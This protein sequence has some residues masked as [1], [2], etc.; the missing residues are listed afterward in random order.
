MRTVS[1][2]TRPL[3]TSRRPRGPVRFRSRDGWL[4]LGAADATSASLLTHRRGRRWSLPSIGLAMLTRMSRIAAVG[5][6]RESPVMRV[7]VSDDRRTE[8]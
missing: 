3:I 6:R 1:R 8:R 2:N 5:R 4:S 7:G